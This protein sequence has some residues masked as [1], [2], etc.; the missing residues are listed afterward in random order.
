[1]LSL[2]PPVDPALCFGELLFTPVTMQLLAAL[3]RV[4]RTV[5]KYSNPAPSSFF[6]LTTDIDFDSFIT[7]HTFTVIPSG[8]A[9]QNR[10][11]SKQ[12]TTVSS[13]LLRGTIA[14]RTY[15]IHKNLS[16]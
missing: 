5:R 2:Y 12:I 14:N 10:T 4:L 11:V 9:K 1:M 3:V 16:I 8:K 13:L 6:T 15:G 7:V